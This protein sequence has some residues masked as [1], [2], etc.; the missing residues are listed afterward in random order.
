MSFPR[1]SR[2]L[3]KAEF[4]NVFTEPL[5]VSQ[6]TLLVLCKSNQKEH[7][8]VGIIVGKRV[9]KHAVTRNRIRRVVRE[10]FRF[11]QARLTGLDIVVIARQQC[12]ILSN[13]KI[14]KGIDDLWERLLK[15]LSS[16]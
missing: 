6:R 7:A 13:E 16:S 10:S 1:R 12:D 8:R 9:A 4:N 2:L 3:T 14:R 15:N 5:K 11:N